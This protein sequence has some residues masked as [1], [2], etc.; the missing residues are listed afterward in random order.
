M[1]SVGPPARRTSSCQIGFF[2]SGLSP[3]RLIEHLLAREMRRRP[4]V[5]RPHERA[6]PRNRLRRPHERTLR[7]PVPIKRSASVDAHLLAI[8]ARHGSSRQVRTDGA[9]DQRDERR[10]R[11]RGQAFDAH[12]HDARAGRTPPCQQRVK[13]GIERDDDATFRAC[14]IEDLL[15]RRACEPDVASVYDVVAQLREVGHGATR[16]ALVEEKLQRS[17]RVRQLDDL[18]VD[19][20]FGI[21]QRLLQVLFLELGVFTEDRGT[22]RV[23]A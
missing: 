4:S 1:P 15:V 2:A 10:H 17:A 7:A 22:I 3:Q 19:E 11:G 9:D 18:V 13:V 6:R 20:G 12:P 16:D 23:G 21:G 8:D 14:P 5:L